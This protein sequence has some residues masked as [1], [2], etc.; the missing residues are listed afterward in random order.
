MTTPRKLFLVSSLIVGAL[1]IGGAW[2][3]IQLSGSASHVHFVLPDGY[4][5]VFK[6]VEDQEGGVYVP[7]IGNRYDYIVPP[8]GL[9]RVTSMEPFDW[10][11]IVRV[12]LVPG[13][14][15]GVVGTAQ[16]T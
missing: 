14:E 2:Y 12:T 1:C 6:L 4:R 7:N 13:R 11:G 3:K 5:G 16:S 9:L 10:S 15:R 8:S